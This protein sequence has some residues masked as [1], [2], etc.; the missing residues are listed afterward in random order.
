MSVIVLSTHT[1]QILYALCS[2]VQTHLKLGDVCRAL[3]CADSGPSLLLTELAGSVHVGAK[4]QVLVGGSM[5][6]RHVG[7]AI[8]LVGGV[9]EGVA[10]ARRVRTMR[11]MM[12]VVVV[13][14][15]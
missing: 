5:L 1:D 15:V 12:M 2:S 14:L 6:I 7:D 11:V 4:L 13:M 9:G 10:A 8:R 3:T